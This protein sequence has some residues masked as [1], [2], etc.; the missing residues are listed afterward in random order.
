MRI[1]DLTAGNR[2]IWFDKDNPLATFLDKR[3]EVNPCFV[4]DIKHI[5]EE[6]G[7]E[8][9]LIVFDP[10]H[11]NVGPNGHMTKRYG[12]S[13]R[14]EIIQTISGAARESH[15]VSKENALMA[16]KWNDHAFKLDRVLDLMSEYWEP[17]FGHHL[18]NRG[19]SEAK[20]Q[21]FWVLLRRLKEKQYIIEAVDHVKKTVTIKELK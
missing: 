3:T 7:N 13:T 9:D 21:S 6:V 17:L 10:P 11:E 4:C 15:R 2:A 14:E 18:R 16:F 20:T 1:L 5:P 19:G 8:F 12:H